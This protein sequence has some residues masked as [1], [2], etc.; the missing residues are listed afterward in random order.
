[1]VILGMVH[2]PQSKASLSPAAIR[3]FEL[4]LVTPELGEVPGTSSSYLLYTDHYLMSW[5]HTWRIIP[6]GYIYIRIYIDYIYR[7]YI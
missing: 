5:K 3:P 4:C 2:H 6:I 7:L 1:M